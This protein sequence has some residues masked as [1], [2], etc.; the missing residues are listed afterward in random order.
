VGGVIRIP[1]ELQGRETGFYLTWPP[2][3]GG[4]TIESRPQIGGQVLWTVKLHS[5]VLTRDGEWIYEV[6]PSSRDPEFIRRTRYSL[7]K[8]IY[9]ARQA[10]LIGSGTVR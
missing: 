1:S 6:T 8:A 10:G 4:A 7:R 3:L 5:A 9:L 2:E